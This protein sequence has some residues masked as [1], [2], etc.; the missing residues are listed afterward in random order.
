MPTDRA[1]APD[2]AYQ[3]VLYESRTVSGNVNPTVNGTS[4]TTVH[5]GAISLRLGF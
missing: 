4:D 2:V 1:A 5:V 3:V